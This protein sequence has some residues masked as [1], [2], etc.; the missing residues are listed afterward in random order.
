MSKT[1]AELFDEEEAKPPPP[2]DPAASARNRAKARAEFEKGVRLG[3]HD[4]EGNSLLPEDEDE[5]DEEDEELR[6]DS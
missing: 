1:L 4:A 3:W 5:E 6:Q 2:E